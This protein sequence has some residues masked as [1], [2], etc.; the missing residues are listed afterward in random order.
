MDVLSDVL[1]MV[2]LEGAFFLNAEF[3]EPWCVDAPRGAELARVL[4]PAAP[5]LGVC[6]L[7][8]AGRCWI[9]L[10]DG[11]APMPLEAG[12]V[13]VLPHGDAHLLGSG[14]QYAPVSLDHVVALELPELAR[15]RYG[16]AGDRTD[17][18]CG[19]FS[20]ERDL[21]NPLISALPRLFRSGLRERGSGPWIEQLIRYA[22]GEAASS[23]AGSNV[24][25][26][27][28]AEVLLIEAV[29]GY[30]D[31]LPPAQSGWL[32]GL[33]DLQVGRCMALMHERPGQAWTVAA[34]AGA[35]NVS[36]TVLAQRF[37]ALV[38]LPPMQY[39]QRW[40]LTVAAH[41]L[42]AG[43]D[44]LGRVAESVGYESE[45]AFN[46]AFKRAYGVPPGLWRR[47]AATAADAARAG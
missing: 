23:H 17:I 40:R 12:D 41:L 10:R 11:G 19:W 27:K 47:S 46:R 33:R 39:L 6:H 35:V 26:A 44:P 13:V 30:A 7:V 21:P 3:H 45:A 1:R 8:L 9:A 37:S 14:L 38:G 43:Q 18:V 29:R 24:V 22:V 32:A 25:A 20:Y 5:E 31:A 28:V 42:S 2:R 36:R 4:R 15:V 16:G 34:L